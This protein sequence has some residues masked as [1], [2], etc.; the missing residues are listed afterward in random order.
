M[1]VLA[2]VYLPTFY[3]FK[4]TAFSPNCDNLLRFE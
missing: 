2:F 4:A 3:V 1:A